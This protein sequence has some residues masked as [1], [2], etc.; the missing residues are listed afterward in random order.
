MKITAV[1]LRF[2][3]R[4][5][6]YGNHGNREKTG[7]VDAVQTGFGQLDNAGFALGVMDFRFY[8]R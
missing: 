1:A 2:R 7:L 6:A 4:H 8:G 3:D 5:E